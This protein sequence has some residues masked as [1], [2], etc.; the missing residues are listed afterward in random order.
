MG[1]TGQG[2]YNMNLLDDPKAIGAIDI[3]NMSKRISN[4]SSMLK[5]AMNTEIDLPIAEKPS[6]VILVGMGGSAIACDLLKDYMAGQFDIPTTVIREP[7]FPYTLNSKTLLIVNSFSGNTEESI[8]MFNKGL[9][10]GCPIIAVTSGGR[11]E[12][13]ASTSRTPLIKMNVTGEPRS[14]VPYHFLL[15]I[16]LF[17][18]LN[19]VDISE[20][21]IHSTLQSVGKC[22]EQYSINTPIKNNLAKQIAIKLENNLPCIYGGGIFKGM[23]L[24]WKTQINENAKSM[25]VNDYIPE[26]FH[27]TIESVQKYE[28]LNPSLF[29]IVIEPNK[30]PKWL[31]K[32]YASLKTL[33]CDY[34]LQ[35]QFIKS[36][37]TS[38]LEQIICMMSLS[39][40]TSFYLGILKNVDPAST[41]VIDTTKK[42]VS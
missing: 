38:N 29:V 3:T 14:I 13:L 41:E 23:T 36:E 20:S 28:A 6:S 8:M 39:D 31:Q 4:A 11:L 18:F 1:Q 2:T 40:Y 37:F 24:R 25:C 10:A 32:R 22:I 27:N 35:H 5:A 19:L 30:N 15:L 12:Q 42:M 16:R 21:D 34:G 33:L 7:L 26:L 17:A 9:E